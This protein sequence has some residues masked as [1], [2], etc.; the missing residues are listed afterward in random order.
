MILKAAASTDS[1]F[2]F[3]RVSQSFEQFVV[4]LGV[5]CAVNLDNHLFH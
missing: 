1:G 2:F 3:W 5:P 4:F